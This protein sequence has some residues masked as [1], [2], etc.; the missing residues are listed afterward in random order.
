MAEDLQKGEQRF[1]CVAQA[2][3]HRSTVDGGEKSL[4]VHGDE[5]LRE[6]EDGGSCGVPGRRELDDANYDG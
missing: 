4:V 6:D 5:G 3:T 1:V 2:P